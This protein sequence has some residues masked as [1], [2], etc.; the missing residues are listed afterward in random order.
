M[1]RIEL[2]VAPSGQRIW[3]PRDCDISGTA[4]G[5]TPRRWRAKFRG[6]YMGQYGDGNERLC[7]QG[8]DASSVPCVTKS[9][10]VGKVAKG[11]NEAS[12]KQ[13]LVA[14]EAQSAAPQRAS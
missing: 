11:D 8:R 5:R 1:I 9:G 7:H 13:S 12:V 6:L 2:L 4:Q 14:Q 3:S 10:D